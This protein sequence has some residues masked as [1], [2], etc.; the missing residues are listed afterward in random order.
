MKIMRRDTLSGIMEDENA[1]VYMTFNEWYNGEGIDFSFNG[2]DLIS[3]HG[4]ELY[5]MMVASVAANMFT[6]ADVKR[7]VFQLLKDTAERE[8]YIE[9]I[10]SEV[11]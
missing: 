2:R 10:R 7:D 3:L 5:A 9:K 11:I 8:H 1:N 4:E 6:I